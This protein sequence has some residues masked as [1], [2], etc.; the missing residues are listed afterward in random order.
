MTRQT[1]TGKVAATFSTSGY[2]RCLAAKDI[3]N[4]HV[5]SIADAMI[6]VLQWVA[7]VEER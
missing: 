5:V 4:P 2:R 6:D 7:E 3:M 1:L